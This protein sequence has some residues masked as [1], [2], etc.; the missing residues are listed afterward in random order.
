MLREHLNEIIERARGDP[1][2]RGTRSMLQFELQPRR[3]ARHLPAADGRARRR[4]TLR[5]QPEVPRPGVE[6]LGGKP[7]TSR[8]SRAPSASRGATTSTDLR[9]A[10]GLRTP[11][12]VVVPVE[13]VAILLLA[14][15]IYVQRLHRVGADGGRTQLGPLGF[16]GVDHMLSTRL[17]R[18][19]RCDRVPQGQLPG[20]RRCGSRAT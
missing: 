17:R 19:R 4:R 10:A 16:A 5:P 6:L 11:P 1:L 15:C 8:R 13:M 20:L 9:G 3:A 7:R 2:P 18:A 14:M 12:D